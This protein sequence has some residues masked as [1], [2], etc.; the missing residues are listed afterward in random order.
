[1]SRKATKVDGCKQLAL[2]ILFSRLLFASDT[3]V[4]Q[5]VVL[6]D[7]GKPNFKIS[8]SLKIDET[9]RFVKSYLFLMIQ[10]SFQI[11]FYQ[12]YSGKCPIELYNFVNNLVPGIS[13]LIQTSKEG[14]NDQ[15]LEALHIKLQSMI[16]IILPN[17]Q[18]LTFICWN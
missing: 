2:K 13:I 7:K 16:N 3:K 18:Q 4:E 11:N 10:S 14:L 12:K 8:L 1:M 5:T 17:F 15:V 6:R 9:K